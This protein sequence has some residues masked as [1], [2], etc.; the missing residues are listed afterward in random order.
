MK[1]GMVMSTK[2]NFV[3][4]ASWLDAI[5]AMEKAQGEAVA[6]K[7]A[8]QII[9]YGVTGELTTDNE[10]IRGFI[11]ALCKDLIHKSKN[12][13]K[14]CKANGQQGGR[15]VQHDPDNIK[16]MYAAGMTYQEIAKE[17]NC[18]VRT[19]QRALTEEDEI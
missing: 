16:A 6:D 12:R 15:P 4:Y 13:Y 10:I 3:F 8:R 17:L 11:D 1:E 5:N 9:Q 19:V 18:S 7:F 2:E 14:A